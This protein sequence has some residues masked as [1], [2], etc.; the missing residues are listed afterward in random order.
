MRGCACSVPHFERGAYLISLSE[1]RLRVLALEPD[2]KLVELGRVAA[3]YVAS[4]V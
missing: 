2:R 1:G 3:T 4:A